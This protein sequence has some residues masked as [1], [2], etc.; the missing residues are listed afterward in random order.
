MEYEKIVYGFHG[1]DQTVKDKILNGEHWIP[2]SNKWDWLGS[3]IY[4]WE[5]DQKRAMDWAIAASQ[6][7]MYSINKPAVIG[8]KLNLKYCLD[9]TTQQSIEV[10]RSGYIS[11]KNQY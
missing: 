9:M 1:C 7:S 8:A 10:A 6:S 2:S 3:G 11:L 4:F 5:Y